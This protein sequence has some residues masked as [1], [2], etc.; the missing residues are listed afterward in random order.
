MVPIYDVI[1]MHIHDRLSHETLVTG[2][3][4][5]RYSNPYV[6]SHPQYLLTLS[7][8]EELLSTTEKYGHFF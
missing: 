6:R 2:T 1:D 8:T 4:I 5:S 3:K 7:T